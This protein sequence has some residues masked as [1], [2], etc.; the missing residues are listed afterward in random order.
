[1][2]ISESVPLRHKREAGDILFQDLWKN[3]AGFIVWQRGYVRGLSTVLTSKQQRSGVCF[4]I[5]HG[6]EHQAKSSFYKL[7]PYFTGLNF[8]WIWERE[9]EAGELMHTFVCRKQKKWNHYSWWW[10]WAFIFFAISSCCFGTE[11][12]HPLKKC[13]LLHTCQEKCLMHGGFRQ[14]SSIPQWVSLEGRWRGCWC[15]QGETAAYTEPPSLGRNL[16]GCCA[17][18]LKS[19]CHNKIRKC[20]KWWQWW[21]LL[22][23]ESGLS[24]V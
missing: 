3:T 5:T 1:M 22:H 8:G 18:R 4:G 10:L 7:K 15:G 17:S 9:G 13:H 20:L 19:Q 16:C 24:S 23:R 6:S 14:S 2:A 21:Y 11:H 12:Y